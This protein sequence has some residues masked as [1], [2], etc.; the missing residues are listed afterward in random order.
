MK[1][2]QDWEND[3]VADIKVDKTDVY[4]FYV[5]RPGDSLSKIAKDVYDNGGLFNK[6]YDANKATIGDNPNMIKPGQK[7]TIRTAERL[8]RRLCSGRSGVWGAPSLAPGSVRLQ[9][10]CRPPASVP[11]PMRSDLSQLA[12]GRVRPAARGSSRRGL[13]PEPR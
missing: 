5:V 2:Y 6:I 4:G 11:R 7:L 13:D 8:A 3:L 9:R 1:T 12:P 10:G